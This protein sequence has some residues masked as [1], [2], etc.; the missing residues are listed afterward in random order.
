MESLDQIGVALVKMADRHSYQAAI[1]DDEITV[2]YE[3]LYLRAGGYAKAIDQETDPKGTVALCLPPGV[4]AYAAILGCVMSGRTFCSLSQTDPDARRQ[5]IL[6]RLKPDLLITNL[7]NVYPSVRSIS[8]LVSAGETFSP[9]KSANELL[10][11]IFTSGSTGQPKGVRIA[12]QGVR[13]FLEW[14]LNFYRPSPSDRWAQFN[15]P[16][17]DLSLVDLFVTFLSGAALVP[18]HATVDRLRPSKKVSR[19][20]VT[21]WHAVPSTVRLLLEGGR[22]SPN[23][24]QSIR[25]FTFCGEPLMTH[26]VAQLRAAVPDARIINTYGPT[27]TTIFFTAHE[28]TE[29]DLESSEPTIPLGDSI[30]GWELE[31]VPQSEE[32]LSEVVVHGEHIGRGYIG[33]DQGGYQGPL[34]R[35]SSFRTGDLVRLTGDQIFFHSRKDRQRKVRGVRVELGEVEKAAFD[36]GLGNTCAEVRNEQLVLFVSQEE[37]SILHPTAIQDRLAR[38]LPI[39]MVPGLIKVVDKF[40]QTAS[41]KIDVNELLKSCEETP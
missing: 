12:E 4:E 11:V 37:T 24:L 29:H 5:A 25:L 6:E 17:F 23:D 9:R 20:G 31:L 10:Y 21:V 36:S 3:E 8:P 18:F 22:G 7:E 38:L 2:T 34:G 39:S 13:R 30:P 33:S 15:V 16:T 41:S 28:V 32:D 19:C 1:V 26:T 35:P 14:A 40:P 27:E